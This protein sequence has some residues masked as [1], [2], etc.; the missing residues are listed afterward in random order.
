MACVLFELGRPAHLS[1]G[2]KQVGR[3]SVWTQEA[4]G[5]RLQVLPEVLNMSENYL[6]R[7]LIKLLKEARGIF[8]HY[9]LV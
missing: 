9:V 8:P 1:L 4:N 6:K 2:G 3:G 7:T 5:L